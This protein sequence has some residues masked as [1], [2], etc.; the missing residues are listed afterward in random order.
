MHEIAMETKY[1]LWYMLLS[2]QKVA[3]NPWVL[4]LHTGKFQKNV[5]QYFAKEIKLNPSL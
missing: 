3:Y 5:Q 4:I 2:M 1:M